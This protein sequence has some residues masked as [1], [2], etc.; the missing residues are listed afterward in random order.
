V[1]YTVQGGNLQT[2][3]TKLTS[4]DPVAIAGPGGVVV[5]IYAAEITGGTPT[6]AIYVTNGTT[7][8]FKRGAKAM[9][10]YEEYEHNVILVL[11]AN[12]TLM[13]DPSLANQIDV[14]VT[15]IPKDMSAK[16]GA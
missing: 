14:A 9:T 8:T 13:A 5:G 11:K 16:G 12:E 10:A 7:N 15:Y 3:Y 2:K 4:V 6:L 1:T